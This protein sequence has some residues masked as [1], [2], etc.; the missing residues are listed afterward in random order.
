METWT[1]SPDR[2]GYRC[3]TIQRGP[4]TIRIWRPILTEEEA[5]K[6]QQKAR[7]GLECAMREYYSRKARAAAV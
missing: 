2:P 7:A 5:E 4:A 3:K 6:A 1:T